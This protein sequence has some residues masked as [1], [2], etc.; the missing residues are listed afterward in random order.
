MSNHMWKN[1]IFLKSVFASSSARGRRRWKNFVWLWSTSTTQQHPPPNLSLKIL[2]KTTLGSSLSRSDS[3]VRTSPGH[4][5]LP[6]A[7][8]KAFSTFSLEHFDH[9]NKNW[10]DC[11]FYLGPTNA[12]PK[13]RRTSKARCNNFWSRAGFAT[14]RPILII[15]PSV[16][17]RASAVHRADQ[18]MKMGRLTRKWKI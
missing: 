11:S 12:R 7:D 13:R 2:S 14:R 4:W 6:V 16:A 8:H 10:S 15:G 3:Y 5:V 1:S 17:Q 9:K 18:K